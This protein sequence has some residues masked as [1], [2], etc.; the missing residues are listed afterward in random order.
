MGAACSGSAASGALASSSAWGCWAASAACWKMALMGD[1]IA[2]SGVTSSCAPASS[3][4]AKAGQISS[5]SAASSAVIRR[6]RGCLSVIY[7]QSFLVRA[8]EFVTVLTPF[9]NHI[10]TFV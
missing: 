6:R 2:S 10:V 7:D 5:A 3:S 9:C 8:G 4:A 1:K